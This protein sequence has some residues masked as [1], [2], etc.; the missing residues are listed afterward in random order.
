MHTVVS[1]SA[2]VFEREVLLLF[3]FLTKPMCPEACAVFLIPSSMK[4]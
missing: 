1:G 3:L 4:Q 2:Y